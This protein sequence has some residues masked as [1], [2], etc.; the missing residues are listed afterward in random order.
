MP[1]SGRAIALLL[2]L[3]LI[4]AALVGTAAAATITE[5]QLGEEHIPRYIKA[6]PDGN[7]WFSDR[8]LDGG[9]GIIGPNGERFGEIA[10]SSNTANDLAF[11]PAGVLY[12]AGDN[13]LGR[14]TAGGTIDEH[15]AYEGYAG[16]FAPDGSWY[17]SEVGSADA[18]PEAE[19]CTGTPFTGGYHCTSFGDEGKFTGL[20]FDSGGILWGVDPNANIIRKMTGES[21]LRVELP[22]GS[23]P[24]RIV[25][26]PDE[27]LW[28]TMFGGDA[29][30][31]IT[32]AGVRTRFS[33]PAGSKPDDI[34][35]GP[36]G[37]LWFTELGT[38]KIG[39]IMTDG[40]VT[41]EFPTP[42][43]DAEPSGITTGPD[44]ALWFTESV[45]N[46]GRLVPG[47]PATPGGPPDG[48]GSAGGGP[49][50]GGPAG[51]GPGPDVT[52]PA[53]TSAPSFSPTHFAVAD[54][55]K[56]STARHGK[57]AT[58]SKVAVSLSEA[59]TV[60][61]TVSRSLPGRRKGRSCV[62]LG[63]APKGAANCKRQ[64]TVGT[65]SWDAAAG[66]SQLPFSGKLGGKALKPGSYSAGL[67]ARDAAGNASAP[68]SATFTVI[69]R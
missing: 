45:G 7:F 1:S 43:A 63:A 62:A 61:A 52:A 30:D 36:D 25:L 32:P 11:S 6:G 26:G 15:S 51:G 21:T 31:R 44:G 58:G 50:G 69:A 19:F 17:W 41:D 56:V 20:A 2:S 59:A 53:F 4:S 27:N 35:V 12:W 37:A 5:F 13:K 24:M 16:T 55:A 39:R 14:R 64:V 8:G 18:G 29:I 46:I 42:T 60:T 48:G 67:V 38:S 28:V 47:S 23:K 49:A 10:A 68:Q 65:Q 9:I 40:T 33:L 54:G 22:L 57:P 3:L 34:T 66:A